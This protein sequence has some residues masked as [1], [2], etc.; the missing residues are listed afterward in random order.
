M[1]VD[2]E[3]SELA[4]HLRRV[5]AELPARI[6]IIEVTAEGLS[7]W[8]ISADRR[9]HLM[10]DRPITR[11]KRH[12]RIVAWILPLQE[13]PLQDHD[14]P[15]PGQDALVLVGRRGSKRGFLDDLVDREAGDAGIDGLDLDFFRIRRSQAVATAPSHRS[16]YRVD[17][18]RKLG[19][20]VWDSIAGT[21]QRRD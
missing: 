11:P 13:D 12:L 2:A 15:A 5:E 17:D 18:P 10:F 21:G 6:Q 20:I 19:E 16:T 3:L 1:T 4:G 14:A 7:D 9:L 8:T